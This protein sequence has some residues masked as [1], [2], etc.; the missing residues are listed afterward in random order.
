MPQGRNETI[1]ERLDRNWNDILQEIRVMQTGVQILAAFLVVLPFQARFTILD[2]GQKIFYLSLLV[3]SALLIILIITPV[4][5]HRHFFGH[6]VK[7]TTVQMGHAISKLVILGVGILVS[8][9]VW[10]V[11]LVL[12][13]WQSGLIVGGA[14][15]LAA[16][17]LLVVLPRT[18]KPRSAVLGKVTSDKADLHTQ[19]PP[20]S[21]ESQ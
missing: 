7:L 1:E 12:A 14:T 3:F 2:D 5:V 9:C 18:I 10:F 13:G 15:V 20:S 21:A 8:G 16:L 4:A 17:F 11:V 19:E 6:R